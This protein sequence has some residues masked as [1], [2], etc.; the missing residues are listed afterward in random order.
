MFFDYELVLPKNCGGSDCY[1]KKNTDDGSWS[2]VM[3]NKNIIV[4]FWP[5]IKL[6]HVQSEKKNNHSKLMF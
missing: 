2:G 4:W 6:N 3:G 5:M 1:G